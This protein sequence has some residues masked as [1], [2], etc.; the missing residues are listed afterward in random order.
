MP[1]LVRRRMNLNGVEYSPGDIIPQSV[2]D[3][4]AP[5]RFGSMVRLRLLEEVTPSQAASAVHEANTQPS[6]Q[7][8]G[9]MCPICGGGPY[10]NLAGHTTKMHKAQEE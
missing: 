9:D 5:G 1:H 8:E 3:A 6:A 4:I 7:A 10:K 2:V